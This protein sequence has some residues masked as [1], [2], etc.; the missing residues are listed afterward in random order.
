V[1]DAGGDATHALVSGTHALGITLSDRQV[2]Q[3]T[4]Y[5]A[6]LREGKRAFN[7]TALTDPVDIALKHF[8]DALTVLT[9]L[10]SRPLRLVDV[11]TG[12]GFPGLPIRIARPEITTTLVE[13]TA[14]KAEWVRQTARTLGLD[15][16]EVVT[17]RAEDLA[18][19]PGYRGS[20]DVATARAVA[21]L[22]VLAELCLPFLRPGGILVAQKTSVG[23]A[24]E[25]PRAR[26]VFGI[27]GA[28]LREAR[29][30]TLPQLPNRVLVVVE[31]MKPAP[32][33]Y[34]RQPGTPSKKPL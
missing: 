20:F 25:L 21:P 13:A 32:G 9:V 2:E 1:P 22:S 12:A 27:L 15:G 5:S 18:H 6:L 23:T 11:G 29:A 31:Q 4:R 16:V 19:R 24:A 7:L 10:P 14:K 28:R 30:L 3:F 17:A 8:V 34:P 33:H 26:H